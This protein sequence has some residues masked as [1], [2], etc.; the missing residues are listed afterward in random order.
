[1]SQCNKG[2]RRPGYEAVSQRVIAAVADARDVDPLELPPL[3]NVVDLDA[4]DRIFE[5]GG[6]G[7]RSGP[8]RVIFTIAGCEVIVHSDGEVEVTAPGN[9]DSSS[10]VANHTN[11]HDEAETTLD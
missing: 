8:G 7:E 1:M 3:Y 4:L 9:W 5:N 6:S 2:D 10:A 11:V